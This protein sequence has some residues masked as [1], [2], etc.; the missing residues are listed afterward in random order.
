MDVWT[1]SSER[2]ATMRTIRTVA[3]I[4]TAA[5]L[6]AGLAACSAGDDSDGATTITYWKLT[7]TDAA[8]KKAWAQTLKGFEEAHPDIKLKVQERSTDG[9]K[10]ALRTALG[11]SGAPDVYW[12][13]A[14]P[15]IGGEY[16][17]AGGSLD[18]AKYYKKYDWNERFSPASMSSVKQYG[19]YDGVPSGQSGAAVFYNKDLFAKAGITAPPTSYKELVEDAD[20]LVAAGI[21]PIEFGGTVNWHLMRLLDNILM[22]E[23]GPKTFTALVAAKANWGKEDCVTPAYEQFHTWTQKYLTKGWAS[24]SDSE[25]NALFFKGDAAM[26]IEGN[27][28]DN[29]LRANDVDTATIGVFMFP[30]GTGQLYGDT[31]NN[32]ITPTS[33]HPDAAAEFLDYLTSEKPQKISLDLVGTRPVNV[34][35]KIDPAT[36]DSLDKEWNPIFADAK[37]LFAF[38]DQGLS[39]AETTEYWRIQ[40]LVA[41]ND[42]DP[43][44]AGAQFQKFIDQ[45]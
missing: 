17:K 40:N 13:W 10:E 41:T 26:V 3:V 35:V 1:H 37:G 39:L 38:N 34:D 25:A 9:H 23:C 36:Q 19:K 42:L 5:M 45:Q 32:Y 7:D 14:G 29:V 20:K 43:S 6:A 44:K 24:L 2:D 4:A 12:S 22:T 33:K 31:S 28:F 8:S 21:T 16:V 18:L 27:W 30:T 15:G 11:T